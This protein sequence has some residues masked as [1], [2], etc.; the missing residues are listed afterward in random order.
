MARYLNWLISRGELVSWEYEPDTFEFV[1]I[2]R[3]SRFYTPD[4]KLKEMD[5]S[6]V[7]WEVKG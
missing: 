3:G 2:K 5:G 4:F 7:Y 1:K 6:T